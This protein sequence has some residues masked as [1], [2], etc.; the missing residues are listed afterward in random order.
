MSASRTLLSVCPVVQTSSTRRT[1][2]PRR[3]DPTVRSQGPL[4]HP[5]SASASWTEREGVLVLLRPRQKRSHGADVTSPI[6]CA[7]RAATS[8]RPRS[9]LH[10]L[11]GQ[12]ITMSGVGCTRA[13]N[14]C[15]RI[16]NAAPSPCT[17]ARRTSVRMIPSYR[18][19]PGLG[20][21][22]ST[23]SPAISSLHHKQRLTRRATTTKS[24]FPAHA[25]H[26][27]REIYALPSANATDIWGGSWVQ[28]ACSRHQGS[29]G[30]RYDRP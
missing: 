19:N 12:G 20:A 17:F 15:V 28:S 5:G 27:M 25:V 24:S 23:L 21:L 7:N 9:R 16:R 22:G 4:S 14:R 8:T 6:S 10:R 30:I 3:F 13:R 11:E 2:L 18:Y 1:E 29:F 26:H